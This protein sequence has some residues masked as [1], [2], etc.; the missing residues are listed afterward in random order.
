MTYINLEYGLGNF[1]KC[2]STKFE[3]ITISDFKQL[4][5]NTLCIFKVNRGW[6]ENREGSHFQ[7]LKS[8]F[9][10]SKGPDLQIPK[11]LQNWWNYEIT[12]YCINNEIMSIIT[13]A[14]TAG[15]ADLI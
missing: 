7:T 8:F 2:V 12:R 5:K 10:N 13:L 3:H 14:P 6:R 15:L 9:N 11:Q 4:P 1:N